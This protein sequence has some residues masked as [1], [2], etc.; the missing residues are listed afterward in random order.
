MKY[1]LAA[2]GGDGGSVA[3]ARERGL[4]YVPDRN[5]QA[6][7]RRSREGAWIEISSPVMYAMP[8]LGR[9]RE[10]AW[11]EI[12]AV[13]YIVDKVYVAPARE[14]G[15]KYRYNDGADADRQSLPRGS[16]D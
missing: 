15:L 13:K 11:I 16:V 8:E 7:C 1:N 6:G 4:K 12:Y 2:K 14:R 5:H 9:S 3:P 10:G